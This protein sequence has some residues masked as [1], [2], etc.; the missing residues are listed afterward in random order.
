M[1]HEQMCR[2][3]LL[4]YCFGNTFAKHYQ[5]ILA[6]HPRCWSMGLQ[7]SHTEQRSTALRAQQANGRH[8]DTPCAH[9]AGACLGNPHPPGLFKS[10]Q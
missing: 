10:W 8:C 1:M 3:E 9:T 4:W 5:S 7:A 2:A 6:L